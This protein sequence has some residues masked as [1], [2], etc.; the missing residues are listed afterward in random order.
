VPKC[1]FILDEAYQGAYH[2]CQM[3]AEYL[4]ILQMPWKDGQLHESEYWLCN[5]HRFDS[6]FPRVWVEEGWGYEYK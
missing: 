1:E 2:Q 4:V 3:P 6:R 5:L